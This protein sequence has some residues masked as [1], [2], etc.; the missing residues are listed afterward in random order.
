MTR[1]LMTSLTI[2]LLTGNSWAE[3]ILFPGPIYGGKG[4]QV[5]FNTFTSPM[6]FQTIVWNFGNLNI[7]T[8]DR[9]GSETVGSEYKGRVS[10]NKTSGALTLQSLRLND[11]GGYAVILTPADGTQTLQGKTVL[12]VF[13]PVTDVNIKGP[14]STLVEGKS[15][16][17]LNCDGTG[18][19]ITTQWIK[20][21]QHL[22]ESDSITF[23]ADNRSMLIN[24]VS[25]SDIGEYVCVHSNPISSEMANYSI[26]VLYG[27]DVKIL[28][29]EILEEGSDILLYCSVSS[30]PLATLTW[31]VKDVDA[32]NSALYITE[33][34]NT[35]HSGIYTCTASNN[36]TGLTTSAQHT[37][38][39]RGK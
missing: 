33:S 9:S 23:S 34:S 26:T 27:P 18:T 4:E 37:V 20:D 8:S 32:G 16:A 31:T 35:D 1:T 15:S 6:Q 39:V 21:G 13:V 17:N 25:R 11:T 7:I 2:I 12:Q 14:N 28:G 10:L 36:I 19:I 30:V 24:P 38:T 3:N 29:A 5:Q 22:S